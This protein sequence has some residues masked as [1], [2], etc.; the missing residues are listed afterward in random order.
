MQYR[1]QAGD[2]GGLCVAAGVRTSLGSQRRTGRALM[3]TVLLC[4]WPRL[5]RTDLQGGRVVFPMRKAGVH[6]ALPR[7][8]TEA[9]YGSGL[10]QPARGLD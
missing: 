3:V 4:A 8:D 7:D 1:E 6:K 9:V 10:A 2:T 5:F